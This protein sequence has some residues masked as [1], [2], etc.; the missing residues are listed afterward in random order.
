MKRRSLRRSQSLHV[1]TSKTPKRHT[2][3][4]STEIGAEGRPETAYKPT[5]LGWKDGHPSE[6][7]A[8]NIDVA[9]DAEEFR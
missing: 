5:K 2:A 7:G 4:V 1:G 3:P 9:P 8:M 6:A